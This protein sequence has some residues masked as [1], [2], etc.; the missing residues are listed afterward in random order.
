MTRRCRVSLPGKD[1]C[2]NPPTHVVTFG[3]G[4]QVSACE[5][6][7][8]ATAELA[9]TFGTVVKVEPAGAP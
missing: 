8:L 3:D 4:D 6:C 5:P 9:K 1:L 2:P 7:A